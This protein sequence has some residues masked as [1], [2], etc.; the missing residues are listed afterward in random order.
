MARC[1]CSFTANP[2]CTLSAIP[3]GEPKVLP[4]YCLQKS[5]NHYTA[6]G[7]LYR[8]CDLCLH[9]NRPLLT[10]H[11]IRHVSPGKE[12]RS[13]SKIAYTFLAGCQNTKVLPGGTRANHAMVFV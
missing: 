5:T 2:Y 7:I 11:Y 12:L 6:E 4:L 10:K 9:F 3:V 1:K 13:H 8:R